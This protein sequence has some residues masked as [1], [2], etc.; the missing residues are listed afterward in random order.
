MRG[1]GTEPV[2]RVMADVA[3]DRPEVEAELLRWLKELVAE[4]AA[5]AQD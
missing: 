2:L 3:G 5:N 1:S 4:S